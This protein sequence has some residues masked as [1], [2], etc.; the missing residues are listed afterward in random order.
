MDW[1]NER[2]SL[3]HAPSRWSYRS[4]SG[5]NELKSTT[6]LTCPRQTAT[7]WAYVGAVGSVAR[8]TDVVDGQRFLPARRI[9][10]QSQALSETLSDAHALAEWVATYDEL[11]DKRQLQANGVTIVRYRR[12]STN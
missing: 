10:V 4:V 9:S 2:P 11:L 12:A 6:F 8:Q 5:E 1:A 7:G 3:E